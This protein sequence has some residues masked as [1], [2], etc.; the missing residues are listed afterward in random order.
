MVHD[1]VIIYFVS[2]EQMWIDNVIHHCVGGSVVDVWLILEYFQDNSW[3]L[4]WSHNL[5][6]IFPQWCVWPWFSWWDRA[7][8]DVFTNFVQSAE[9]I[10]HFVA[11]PPGYIPYLRSTAISFCAL[12]TFYTCSHL[13]P[14]ISTTVSFYKVKIGF[15]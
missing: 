5:Y 2:T 12:K 15:N 13:C 1:S 7:F 6:F 9:I 8:Q 10:E 14:A 3:D 11:V 4:A